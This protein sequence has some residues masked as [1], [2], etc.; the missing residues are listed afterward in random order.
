M[1]VY[2]MSGIPGAGK[3]TWVNTHVVREF[4]RERVVVCS[5]DHYH[6]ND[7]GEYQWR[8]EFAAKAHALCLDKFLRALRDCAEYRR[9]TQGGELLDALVCDNT[10]V[11]AWE[12][13][14]YVRLAELFGYD[15]EVVRVYCEPVLAVSRNTHKVPLERVMQMYRAFTDNDFPGHWKVRGVVGMPWSA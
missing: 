12:A 15:C 1:K 7:Q 14:P 3:S 4:P 2:V 11:R 9:T 6:V 8:A 13:S 5:A 10:N